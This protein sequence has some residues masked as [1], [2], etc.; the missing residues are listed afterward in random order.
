MD[1]GTP[2]LLAAPYRRAFF[3]PVATLAAGCFAGALCT[4]I[5]YWRTADIMWADFSAWLLAIGLVV[6]GIAA[7]AGIVDLATRRTP[8]VQMRGLYVAGSILVWLVALLNSLVH[9]RDA[10]TSVVPSGLALSA[11]AV[12]LILVTAWA[13]WP[14][15][16]TLEANIGVVE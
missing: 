15:P 14:A 10:W 8:R 16:V 5:N 1:P 2:V 13:G 3:P 4:D 7:V 12:V 11:L 6:G 9:S